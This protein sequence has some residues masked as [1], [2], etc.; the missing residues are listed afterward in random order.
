MAICGIVITLDSPA[1]EHAASLQQRARA[2]G[3][4]LTL[5]NAAGARLPAVLETPAGDERPATVQQLFDALLALP[6][7]AHVD[8]AYA[9]Y[10][11]QDAETP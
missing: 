6:G 3:I 2:Q 5:G 9:H 10:D 7:V 8:L 11:Q 1:A 4:A